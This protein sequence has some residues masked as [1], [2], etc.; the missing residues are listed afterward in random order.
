MFEYTFEL[1]GKRTT[2]AIIGSGV[3]ECRSMF[4]IKPV[5]KDSALVLVPYEWVVDGTVKDLREN[6]A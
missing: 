6:A 2:D 3:I 5:K 4:A 1:R